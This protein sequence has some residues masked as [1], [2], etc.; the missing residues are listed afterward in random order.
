MRGKPLILGSTAAE[1]LEKSPG[2]TMRLSG[3]AFRVV[4]IYETGDAFEDSAAIVKLTDAQEIVGKPRQV[5]LIYIQLKDPSLSERFMARVE[6]KWT[7]VSISGVEEFADQQ[8]IQDMLE[9]YVWVI[10]GMAILIGGVG[11]MNSQ[12]MAVTE[13]TREIGVLRAV[14]WSSERVLRLILGETVL[15][16]LAGGILGVVIGWALLTTLASGTLM[17]GLANADISTGLLIQ[18]FVIVMVL[19]IVGGLYPAWRA[20]RL[21]PVEALR[22]EG[23]SSGSKV[24]RLPF[25]GMALQSLWQ[26]SL[27]TL[28][29]LGAIGLTVGSIL[30][31]EGIM[32][33]MMAEM[34]KMFSSTEVMIR[35]DNI[36]DTSLSVL[37]ERI[38]EK[39]AAMSNVKSAGGMVFS[40]IALPDAGAFFIL[41]GYE[42]NGYAI[43]RFNVVEGEPLKSNHQVILGRMMAEALNKEVGDTLELSGSR[44]RIVGI[45]E[46][47][48]GMEE[49][50]G[51]LTLRDAQILTG[52]PRKVTMYAVKLSDPSQAG[53]MVDRINDQFPD[54]L[55]SLSSEFTEQMPDFQNSEA[56]IGGM[57]YVALLLG[58]LGVLNAM[59]MAVFERTREIGVLRSLGWRRRSVLAMVLREAIWLGV[60]GGIVG[61][62]FAI[63]LVF[64][65]TK[66]PTIGSVI[67]P[68]FE[69]GDIIRT[70]GIALMLGLL[71]GLYPGYRAT[72][73]QPVEAL[74]YE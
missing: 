68:L 24:R 72:R 42:P 16:S 22:Y 2:D 15:V 34:T 73:M 63:S 13:R 52:R 30:A 56:M 61:V 10:G 18:A 9:A 20:A 33:G 57:S 66:E 74:R 4:G 12:L 45:Y 8:I 51:V 47:Q 71:G 31:L 44:F 54:A 39:I 67:T 11:M 29:T 17:M 53:V 38:G 65:I 48:T 25:G 40:A 27:R 69:W 49:M 55:A 5:S 3:S 60:L 70:L 6:R 50:G 23:G 46:S 37:D 64:L 36:S 62:L 43:Q 19:G 1:V 35:Q 58:G 28:L 32:G 7:E 41:W 59:L 14:G 26:R 21:Q